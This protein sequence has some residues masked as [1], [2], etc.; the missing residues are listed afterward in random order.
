[1]S[2]NYESLLITTIEDDKQI[3]NHLKDLTLFHVQGLVIG[4]EKSSVVN[5][6]I[7]DRLFYG[8]IHVGENVYF[9]DPLNSDDPSE[10]QRFSKLNDPLDVNPDRDPGK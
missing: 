9:V 2:K 10:K 6:F 5:G 1:M 4:E 3:L 7:Q 8:N